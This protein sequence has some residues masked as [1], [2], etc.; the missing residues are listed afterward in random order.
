MVDV[1]NA[2]LRFAQLTDEQ[3]EVVVQQAIYKLTEKKSESDKEF[4]TLHSDNA[5][6]IIINETE[7]S[8]PEES[9]PEETTPEETTP[10]ETTPEETTPEESAP[11]EST[12][13]E[14][15]VG[16][17][18]SDGM[19]EL[20]DALATEVEQIKGDGEVS[21]T[22]VIGFFDN[23]MQMVTLL[24]NAKPKTE[25]KKKSS[26]DYMVERV[27]KEFDTKDEMDA[28]LK[29]HP[30]ADKAR[31]TFKKTV[32]QTKP[33]APSSEKVKPDAPSS[34]K[35]KSDA[36][37]AEEVTQKKPP[38]DADK[39]TTTNESE[40]VPED[41]REALKNKIKD[42]STKIKDSISGASKSVKRL[43]EDEGYRNEKLKSVANGIKGSPK[44][45]GKT[46]LDSA[47]AELKEIK[48][49][50]HAVGKLAKGKKLD[51]EDKHALYAAGVYVAG[52]ALAAVTGGALGG[53]LALG[54]SFKLHVAIKALHKMADEG[55]LG[56]EAYETVH[57]ALDAISH[58]ASDR[59]AQDE[60]EEQRVLINWL[61]AS[62]TRVLEEGI[63]KE[64]MDKILDGVDYSDA[65]KALK[66]DFKVK[67]EKKS[68][69]KNP[70]KK[71]TK[72][73]AS[74]DDIEDEMIERISSDS[75]I[76][77]V[78]YE[79]FSSR[80]NQTNRKDK[81]TMVD[82]GGSSKGREREPH[83]KPPRD[84]VKNRFKPKKKIEKDSDLDE[85]PDNRPD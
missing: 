12:P 55:F 10:E 69:K 70:A 37:S 46:L 53:A 45:V 32:P 59:T 31:H 83:F 13:E 81:D 23:M 28:Y 76:D 2:L 15:D 36:P 9:T 63:S 78:A 60:E 49:A 3:K 62:V 34:E 5:A 29:E 30:D 56:F 61:L 14:T 48:H 71:K 66:V 74:Q 1:D 42:F 85:D 21:S 39:D 33:D 35:V 41:K 72:K 73:K 65:E 22:E 11:E 58:I 54:H 16:S 47:K 79:H 38:V 25:R 51:K 27:A 24:I 68:P 44:K 80:G 52:T 77:R 67:G 64:E 4:D 40:S 57:H 7:E 18:V 20:V 82:T 6:K 19:S 50:G 17:E 43:T 75:M 26:I 8:T 84:D